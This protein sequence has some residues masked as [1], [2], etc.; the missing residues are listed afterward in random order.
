MIRRCEEQDFESIWST[1]NDGAQNYKGVIPADCYAEP[2]MPKDELRR[3]I[4]DGIS[5]WAFEEDG[6]LAGVMGIQYVDDVT[7]IRHAFVR[8]D[9]QQQGIGG[10][11]LSH[12]RER[13]RGPVL[14]GAW[15]AATW[16]IRFYEKHGFH[17]VSPEEKERLLRRYWKISD[18][19]VETS[20]VMAEAGWQAD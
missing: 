1:I 13:A 2:Y 7:L 15:T 8:R 12:L 4:E 20:V 5:F 9:R 11:L 6:A 18:R 3:E 16:A 14:I 19:Q 17:M 10:R